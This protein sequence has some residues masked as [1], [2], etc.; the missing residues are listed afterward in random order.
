MKNFLTA[1]VCGLAIG[2]AV[3]QA[4]SAHWPMSTGTWDSWLEASN[5][6]GLCGDGAPVCDG[7]IVGTS[8][9]PDA[10]ASDTDGD[11]YI[12]VGD[13]SYQFRGSYREVQLPLGK[14]RDTYLAFRVNSHSFS[15]GIP[16]V[17]RYSCVPSDCSWT[18]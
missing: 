1:L 13:H 9:Y 14:H 4:A 11:G 8:K 10:W 15:Y 6:D 16:E 5:L 2:A 18:W 3:P 17:Y 12:R 7:E